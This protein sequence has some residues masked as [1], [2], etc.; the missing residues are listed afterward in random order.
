MENN[1]VKVTYTAGSGRVPAVISDAATKLVA[2][3]LLRHND[4]TVM[5]AETGSQIDIK[6]KHDLLKEE[7]MAIINGKKE[8]VFLIE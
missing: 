5:I 2:V 8:S 4:Q 6:T 1:S 7:A 3:E